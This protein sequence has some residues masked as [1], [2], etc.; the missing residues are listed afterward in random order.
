MSRQFEPVF[1]SIF[2]QTPREAI[3]SRRCPNPPLGC[4]TDIDL[5]NEFHDELSYKEWTLSG[6][7]QQCQDDLFDADM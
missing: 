4:G 3:D 7:C 2:G 6:L 5:D 1:K